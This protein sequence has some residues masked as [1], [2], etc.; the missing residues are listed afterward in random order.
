MNRFKPDPNT[1]GIQPGRPIIKSIYNPGCKDCKAY[2]HIQECETC[3]RSCWCHMNAKE[4]EH[5]RKLFKLKRLR[6]DNIA[7]LRTLNLKE[8][9]NE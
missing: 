4:I 3:G 8:R 1:N 9:I 6:A 5:S 7:A 2:L